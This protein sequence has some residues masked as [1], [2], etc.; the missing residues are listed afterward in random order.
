MA[1]ADAGPSPRTATTRTAAQEG[2]P[3]PAGPASAGQPEQVAAIVADRRLAAMK[4]PR[5]VLIG[6][7]QILAL[8]PGISR[9]GIVMVTGMV[10]GLSR[11]DAARYSFLLSAPVILAAGALK[12]PDL[13]GP[14]GNG[15]RGQVLAGSL[16]SGIGA[17]LSIRFLVRYFRQSRPLTP[18]GIYC[19]AAGLASVI[20]LSVR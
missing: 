15:I 12:I 20:Y 1:G 11:E 5:A 8:L 14:L 6:S 10:R 18:F 3:R 7:A 16:L 17:Y 13:M 2:G 19:L 9:D 4:Y